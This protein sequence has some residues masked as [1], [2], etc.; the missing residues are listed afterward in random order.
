MRNLEEYDN[1]YSDCWL[2]DQTT[3]K[4]IFKELER[5]GTP[6]F[7]LDMSPDEEGFAGPWEHYILIPLYSG[8]F[9]SCITYHDDTHFYQIEELEEMRNKKCQ[10]VTD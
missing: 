4:W 10:V 7:K 6:K 2:E 5:R 1:V 3:L 8:V 9:I